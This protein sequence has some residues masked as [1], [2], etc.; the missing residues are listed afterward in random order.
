MDKT[1]SLSAIRALKQERSKE[2]ND[3]RSR[4]SAIS[5]ELAEL[6]AAEALVVR[7]G[8]DVPEGKSVREPHLI[9]QIKPR[10]RAPLFSL[11][12]GHGKTT[13]TRDLV[14]KVMA[15]TEDPWTN[16]N[17]IQ[18]RVSEMKGREVPMSTISPTLS[19]LKNKDGLI[20][21]EGMKVALAERLKQAGKVEPSTG[22]SGDGS[23]EAQVRA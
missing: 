11:I 13:T 10:S 2:A 17:D 4:L 15:E 20:V 23:E 14:L 5:A 18:A 9:Y 6:D 8:E 19:D 3:L 16:A 1:L 22:G 7:L 12:T 21:R